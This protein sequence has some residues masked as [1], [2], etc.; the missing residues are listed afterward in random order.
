MKRKRIRSERTEKLLVSFRPDALQAIREAA[1]ADGV[2]MS[3][4]IAAS[5]AEHLRRRV[6]D[7]APRTA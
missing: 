1:H 5:V 3:R 4:L 7:P 2:S 6:G